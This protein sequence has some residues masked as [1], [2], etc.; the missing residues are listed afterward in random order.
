MVIAIGM[1]VGGAARCE[2]CLSL[3]S[4]V[5]I[6]RCNSQLHSA[7]EYNRRCTWVCNCGLR[8]HN[9]SHAIALVGH[10]SKNSRE[11]VSHLW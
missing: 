1:A 5:I 6:G 4:A 2:S 9:S 8:R 10:G 7:Q 3:K 11:Q